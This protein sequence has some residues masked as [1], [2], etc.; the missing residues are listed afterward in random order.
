MSM[1]QIIGGVVG[2]VIGYMVGGPTGAMM[3]A[4]LGAGIGGMIDP[5]EPDSPSP[6]QP[7]IA[8]L[9]MTTAQEGS[10]IMDF[11]GTTKLAGNIIG[12]FGSR[13]EEITEEQESGGK[14]GSDSKEVVVGLE[15]H[16]SWI[17]GLGVGPI[18]E[19]Y[20]ILSNDKVVWSGNLLRSEAV[21]GKST[22]T[23]EGMG[24]MTFFFGGTDQVADATIG[25]EFGTTTNPSYRGLTYAFFNDCSL[26]N[27]NRVPTV[28]FVLRKTPVFG[29]NANNVISTYDYNPAHAIWY[30]LA[31]QCELDTAWLNTTYFS[32]FASDIAG[33]DEKRGV[34]MLLK[35][36]EAGKFINSILQH[37]HGIMPYGDDSGQ[38]EPA[39]I[40]ASA[41]TSALTLITDLDCLE[42]PDLTS[43][44]YMDTINDVKV[45]YSQIYD[46]YTGVVPE[47]Q[48]YD[49]NEEFD[50]IGL[51][52]TDKWDTRNIPAYTTTG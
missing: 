47:S 11:L 30:L 41:S 14:G 7:D 26:G 45:Q 32:N 3:G 16:L 50:Y 40:R 44:S 51:A 42:P 36:Q 35:H 38:F 9:D 39:L 1:G 29:F 17:V 27:Y 19:V 21:D 37:V 2:G 22:V 15:Y 43:M 23:L 52:A 49:P 20:T 48:A 31:N 34:S 13:V 5:L 8:N 4:S 12:Y 28:R 25:A 33:S 24:S 6:G 46:F 18:D 10:V